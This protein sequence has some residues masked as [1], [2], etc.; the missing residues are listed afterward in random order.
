MLAVVLL[1]MV[2][3]AVVVVSARRR[4]HAERVARAAIDE[5][6]KVRTLLGVGV[7]TRVCVYCCAA[8]WLR[9]CAWLCGSAT[10]WLCGCMAVWLC[11]CVSSTLTHAARVLLPATCCGAQPR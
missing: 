10:V 11:G 6:H 5:V 7:G 3:C 9:L 1:D 2:I 8:V 4:K